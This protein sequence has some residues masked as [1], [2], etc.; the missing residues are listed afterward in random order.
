MTS[1]GAGIAGVDV[2]I[3]NTI[4]RHGDRARRD[5]GQDDPG[6]PDPQQV[7]RE[8]RLAPGQQRSGEREGEG[9]HGMLELDHFE[10]EANSLKKLPQSVTI[11]V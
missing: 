4:K 6:Q 2:G 5:H 3:Q 1:L 7:A 11:L 9:E 8:S 10:R